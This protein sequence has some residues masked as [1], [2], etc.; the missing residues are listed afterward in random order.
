MAKEPFLLVRRGPALFAVDD[1]TRERLM[2]LKEGEA[3][4]YHP[5]KRARNPRQHALYW[6]LIGLLFENQSHYKT[7][8]QVSNVIKVGV[9]HC[10]T[11]Q[12]RD[13]S[14]I[15]IP[16]SIAFSEMSQEEFEV[17]LDAVL[18]FAAQEIVPHISSKALR[19]EVELLITG[20]PSWAA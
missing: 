16:D 9:G 3:L 20:Q 2:R 1:Y 4:R 18:D 7:K 12:R 6:A 17:F 5:P 11:V 19:R 14:I 10:T 8:E 13:G 15:H